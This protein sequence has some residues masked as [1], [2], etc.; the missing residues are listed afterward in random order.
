MFDGN[1]SSLPGGSPGVGL[2]GR[3]TACTI[4]SYS[5]LS[6][7]WLRSIGSS[8]FSEFV[9]SISVFTSFAITF[10]TGYWMGGSDWHTVL[11]PVIGLVL[12]GLPAAAFGG[13]PSKRAPRRPLTICVGSLALAIAVYRTLF[14][15]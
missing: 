8:N 14:S 4:S 6:A 1:A 3:D 13:Y 15:A 9:V 12:S 11:V 10:L 5:S 7:F 2:S